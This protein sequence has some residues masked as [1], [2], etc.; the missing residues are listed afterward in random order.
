MTLLYQFHAQK[1][2]L[3]E[4][5]DSKEFRDPQLF[6][7]PKGMPLGFFIQFFV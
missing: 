4:S 7:D 1:A 3:N 2:L 5:M 6:D